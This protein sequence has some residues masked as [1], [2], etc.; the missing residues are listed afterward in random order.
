MN[1]D[2]RYMAVAA[3][4]AGGGYL[5]SLYGRFQAAAAVR[6]R[7]N[8]ADVGLL[9]AAVTGHGGDWLFYHYPGPMTALSIVVV[10][11]AVVFGWRWLA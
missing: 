2:L 11:F 9:D 5:A 7:P 3:L 4:G 8:L 1:A 10:T 6:V